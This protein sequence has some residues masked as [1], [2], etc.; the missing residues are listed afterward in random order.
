MAAFLSYVVDR[1]FANG[2]LGHNVLP[3]LSDVSAKRQ[4]IICC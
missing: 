4:I 1:K 2:E 3:N